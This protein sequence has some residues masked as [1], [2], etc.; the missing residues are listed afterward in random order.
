MNNYKVLYPNEVE[1][2]DYRDLRLE[3]LKLE[4]QAFSSSYEDQKDDSDEEW[5][6]RLNRYIE[7]NGNWMVFAASDKKLVGMMGAF[8]TEDDVR[9][10]EA[11]LIAVYVK[12]DHRGKGV[13]KLLISDL[14]KLLIQSNIKRVK[15]TVNADQMAAVSLYTSFRFTIINKERNKLGDGLFHDEY[16]MDKEL[17]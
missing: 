14:L 17:A 8:Q 11:Q 12:K 9:D 10:R 15:L 2:Q 1:W 16:V 3:A 6:S 7:G 13:S 4:P 5:K